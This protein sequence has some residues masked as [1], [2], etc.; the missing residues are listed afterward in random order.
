MTVPE[1][2]SPLDTTGLAV[3]ASAQAARGRPRSEK[4]RKAILKATAALL[5]ERGLAAVSMD[6]VALRAGVSKATIYRWWP[7]K[8][9]VALDAL[10][11]RWEEAARH[12]S[13]TGSLRGDLLELL[14][15]WAG[16]VRTAPYARVIA[17][18]LTRAQTDQVFG[19]EYRRR[20][21]QP[22]RDQAREVFLRAVERG[23]VAA[24]LNLEVALD[25]I[26]GPLYHRL[27]QGHAP[28]DD[29]FVTDVVDMVL[30]GI[31]LQAG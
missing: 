13:D 20:I 1:P 26:Y 14:R 9:A 12:P 4:A 8:E 24:D 3:P 15:P 17:A 6:A 31:R 2:G 21:V 27:L 5:L 19:A 16:I 22:R 23:E 10:Y 11:T 25:L 30:A 18:L 28:L 29:A 7:T